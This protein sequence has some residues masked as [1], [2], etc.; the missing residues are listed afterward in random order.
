[1]LQ[2]YLRAGFGL[3][4]L[5]DWTVFI[6][7]GID[8]KQYLRFADM[9]AD[10]G[11]YGFVDMINHVCGKYLGLNTDKIPLIFNN[12]NI[13]DNVTKKYDVVITNPP[14]R[15]GKSVY[16]T[17]INAAFNHLN[18]D[19]ELWFVMRNN[20]GVKTII[21]DLSKKYNTSVLKKDAGYY[22][23]MVKNGESNL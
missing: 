17:I 1:M 20:H 8:E 22:V 19:G 2:H 12:S 15:A 5:C 10:L 23:V 7:N 11:I 16:L 6:N 9:A 18:V 21:K 4:L 13:Y 3:K 14:I